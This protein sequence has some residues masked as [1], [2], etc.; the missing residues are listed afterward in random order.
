MTDKPVIVA[1]HLTKVYRLYARPQE[2][3]LDILGVRKGRDFTEHYALDDLT[4]SIKGGER[5]GLI[6]R[7]GAGKSTF[8]KI[9]SGVTTPTSGSLHVEGSARALLEIGTGFHPEFTGRENAK[10]YL[11]QLGV[12]G[13]E[14]TTTINEIID[15]AELEEYIDQPLKTY[16]TGMK[17]RLMFST[18]TVMAPE[19]LIL[20][21]VLGVGDAYFSKKSFDRINEMCFRGGTTLLLVSHDIYTA[22]RICDR[23]VWLEK[24]RILFDG[25]PKDAIKA[26]EGSIRQQEE[27]RLRHKSLRALERA[28]QTAAE[29]AGTDGQSDTSIH[30]EVTVP[31]DHAL[32]QPIWFS[33]VRLLKGNGELAALPVT[34]DNPEGAST[35]DKEGSR[36]GPV[37][38][39]TGISARP[40][41]EFGS[42]FRKVGGLFTLSERVKD[43]VLQDMIVELAWGAEEQTELMVTCRTGDR[44]VLQQ[45]VTVGGEGWQVTRLSFAEP[46]ISPEFGRGGS[47]LFG[48]GA[49]HIR[50]VEL[51]DGSGNEAFSFWHGEEFHLSFGYE[52]RDPA[53]DEHCDIVVAILRGGVD[54]ACRLFTRSLWL[55]YSETPTGRIEVGLEKLLLGSGEYSISVLIA[56]EGYFEQQG[57]LFYSINPDVHV[58]I[59]DMVDFSVRATGILADGTSWVADAVWELLPGGSSPASQPVSAKRNTPIEAS[60]E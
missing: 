57:H 16:S 26:Y 22:G 20:D 52:I 56:R 14:A 25:D 31:P 54:T 17:V 53:L 28:D 29:R 48:T 58:S 43:D 7:N 39:W 9:V 50:D 21:E 60:D 49:V 34:V 46:I 47:A 33:A 11:A 27:A 35:L 13:R 38:E 3:I 51:R 59:R 37:T 32:E 36:W 1:E 30:L 2:R 4:L 19:L 41:Q 18:S 24:G 8:L 42:P 55:S 15:F 23:M 5:V 44:I 6:G 45:L 12:S 40:M 10:A